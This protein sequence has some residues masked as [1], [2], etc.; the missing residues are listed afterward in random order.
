MTN[1]KAHTSPGDE[2]VEWMTTKQTAELLGVTEGE[3]RRRVHGGELTAESIRGSMRFDRAV[4]EAA[5]AKVD[6]IAEATAVADDPAA[7]VEKVSGRRLNRYPLLLTPDQAAEVLGTPRSTVYSMLRDGVLPVR[8]VGRTKR[9][10]LPALVRWLT[11]HEV[12]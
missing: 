3:V 10:P 12:A 1:A 8:M 6:R 9:V 11:D 5:R 2:P 4:V 7:L